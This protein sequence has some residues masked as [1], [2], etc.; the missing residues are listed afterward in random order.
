VGYHYVGKAGSTCPAT[1]YQ[2]LQPSANIASTPDAS[3]AFV[4]TPPPPNRPKP[5]KEKRKRK[6]KDNRKLCREYADFKTLLG[7][8]PVFKKSNHLG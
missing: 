6:K 2:S 5:E 1:L 8:A 7:P 3:A 4:P